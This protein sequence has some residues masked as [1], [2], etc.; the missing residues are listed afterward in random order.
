MLPKRLRTGLLL[1]L[2]VTPVFAG[3]SYAMEKMGSSYVPV[4]EEPFD[5]VMSQDKA[6]KPE[7]MK[8]HLDLLNERYDLTRR[9]T[10]E[11]TMTGGKPLPVGPTARLKNGLSWE[12]LAAMGAGRY[13]RERSFPLSAAPPSYP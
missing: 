7:V 5:K 1:T 8:R 12:K 9:V 6:R 13:P 11:V 2:V 4:V 3:L 10:T